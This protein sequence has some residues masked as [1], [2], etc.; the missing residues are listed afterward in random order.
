MF[1]PAP[2]N[3]LGVA[4]NLGRNGIK[5]YCVAEHKNEIAYSKYCEKFYVIPQIER[6]KNILREFLSNIKREL[7]Y[8]AVIFPCS[9]LFCISLSQLREEPNSVLGDQYVTFGASETI[10]TLV[11]KRKFYQSLDRYGVPHPITYFPENHEDIE[12]ISKQVEY[13]VYVRPA[14][15][16][17]FARFQK[18]GFVAHSRAELI[19]FYKLTSRYNIEVMIQEIIPGPVTNMFGI[20]GYF[21][22]THE[23]RAFLA[24]HRLREYPHGFGNSSLM[25]SI[26]ISEVLPMKEE[27]EKYLRKLGYHG[28]FD[29]E[30]KKYPRDGSFKLL[31]IN[32]RSWWQNSFPTKCGI[33]LI[34]MAYLDAI[35][36]DVDHADTYRTGVRWLFFINDALSSIQ[37]LHKRQITIREWLLSFRKVEDYAYLSADDPL[38]WIMSFLFISRKYAQILHTKAFTRLLEI[39][40]GRGIAED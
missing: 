40:S 21:D 9:D 16:Q 20:V 26:P 14:I 36:E 13:P 18:K 29:A 38:P 11:N 30:F 15:S 1:G 19:N 35:G 5:V 6:N 12:N 34:L 3:G 22:K 23:P 33:N 4:R 2:I 7:E 8:P 39:V 25:E 32:A 27:I 28:I 37:M 10:E 24:Y 31:E 17:L